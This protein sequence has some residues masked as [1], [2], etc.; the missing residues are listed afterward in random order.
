MGATFIDSAPKEPKAGRHEIYIDDKNLQKMADDP[1]YRA[2]VFSVIQIE[3]AGTRG[4]S[5]Q[6]AGGV[7]NDRLTGTALSMADG[8][9]IYEGVP[10]S[11]ACVGT[12]A[13]QT[14]SSSS[15]GSAPKATGKKSKSIM[16]MINERIEKRLEEKREKD[17]SEAARKAREDMLE[18]SVEASAKAKDRA[19]ERAVQPGED[20]A[21]PTEPGAAGS[22][23]NILA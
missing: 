4:Y 12:G 10:H 1:E 14:F 8:D 17:K 23:L 19:V 2:Q 3:M 13:V 11:G 9:P 6:G 15:G 21:A 18:I 5:V 7:I 20:A 22:A 16:D